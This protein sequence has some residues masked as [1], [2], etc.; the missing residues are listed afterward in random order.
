[1]VTKGLE[2]APEGELR[3]L[4]DVLR[5]RLPEGIRQQVAFAA[6]GGPS[7]AGELAARRHTCVVFTSRKGEVLPRLRQLFQ[8]PYYHIGLRLTWWGSRCAWR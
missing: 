5:D 6:I 3:L 2:S 7:I 4:P 1:M 8:T